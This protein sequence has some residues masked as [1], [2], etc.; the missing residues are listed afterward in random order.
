MEER[1]EAVSAVCWTCSIRLVWFLI[2]CVGQAT[3]LY[4]CDK[5]FATIPA[6]KWCKGAVGL[7]RS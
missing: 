6:A 2:Q 4:P 7:R 5:I 1:E 3:L